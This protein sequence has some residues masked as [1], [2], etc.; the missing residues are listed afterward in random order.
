MKPL[1]P[2][3]KRNLHVPLPSELYDALRAEAARA[4]QPATLLARQAIEAWIEKRRAEA[5]HEEITAYAARHTGTSLDFDAGL[6][7]AGLE[8]FRGPVKKVRSASPRRKAPE[9]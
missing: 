3:T 5:L 1:N 9:K 6:E 8:L 4:G 2:T 7:A